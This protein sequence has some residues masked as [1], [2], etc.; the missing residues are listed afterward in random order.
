VSCRLTGLPSRENSKWKSVGAVLTAPAYEAVRGVA[1]PEGLGVAAAAAGGGTA[2]PVAGG[3]ILGV[4][5]RVP[6]GVLTSMPE[7]SV[8]QPH[9]VSESSK[10]VP[11]ATFILTTFS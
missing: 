8:H 5:T 11:D 9:V 3:A 2:D 1:A 4:A 10:Y 6:S 7:P